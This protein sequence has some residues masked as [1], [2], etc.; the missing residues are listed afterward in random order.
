MAEGLRAAPG[1]AGWRDALYR[2][3]PVLAEGGEVDQQVNGV[4]EPVC[5]W[6]LRIEHGFVI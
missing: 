6:L 2:L 3:Q 4:C 5:E 1:L